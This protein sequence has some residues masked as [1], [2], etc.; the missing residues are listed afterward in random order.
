MLFLTGK[1]IEQ[2]FSMRDAIEADKKAFRI[3][4]EGASN[5]PLR[6]NIGIPKYE[7]QA[8][9]MPGY[10][11]E[12]DSAG[13]KIVSVFPRNREKGKPVVP[14]TM[15][16]VNAVTG[17]VSSIMDG[18]YITQLRTGAASGVA[19][20]L[21]ARKDARIGAL[22]GT[23][24]Q[25]AMQ[26]VAMLTVRE[27]AE[28]RIFDANQEHA[29]TFINRMAQELGQFKASLRLV[30]TSAEAV[31]GA[32]I[33]TTVTTSRQPVFDGRL[34]KAGSHVNAI[35]SYMPA[36]QEIDEY[37]VCRAD[38]IFCESK[39]MALAEAGDFI[40]PLQ[41]GLIT[42]EKVTGEIGRVISGDLPGRE[43]QDEITLFKSVG[44]AVVDIVTAHAVYQ[45]AVAKGIGLR[46]SY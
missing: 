46:L 30:S 25:A 4:S 40:V 13:V 8:L 44:M 15:V 10:I 14:A 16:L 36:M 12:L 23:G 17:E 3:F 19:T 39:E 35:G 11:E 41:K 22:I 18:T 34:V 20:E 45:K 9:F 43:N 26:L 5:T 28:V 27:L 24:G 7:G 29:R 37:I 38:K 1:D 42:P 2:V 33:I 31:T 32:D 6:T 21:L